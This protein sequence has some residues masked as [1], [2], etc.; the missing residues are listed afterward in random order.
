MYYFAV[1]E[2]KKKVEDTGKKAV[3]EGFESV[4]QHVRV[5]LFPWQAVL[6]QL[7]SINI[8]KIEAV[9]WKAMAHLGASM[10]ANLPDR[11][12]CNWKLNV[13]LYM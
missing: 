10:A 9:A 1:R 13:Y 8:S 7:V 11:P 2:I 5:V 6:S 3:H 12:K 4:C